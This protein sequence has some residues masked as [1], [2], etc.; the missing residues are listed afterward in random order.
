[1]SDFLIVNTDDKLFRE[2]RIL[3]IRQLRAIA[4][5]YYARFLGYNY[6][7]SINTNMINRNEGIES[8][9][10]A[11]YCIDNKMFE[12]AIEL[13]FNIAFVFPFST[14]ELMS[15][16]TQS[17]MKFVF[18][19]IKYRSKN[20]NKKK[21]K[22]RIHNGKVLQWASAK[23]AESKWLY[24]YGM[25]NE[26]S[27]QERKIINYKNQWDLQLFELAKW[28]ARVDGDFYQN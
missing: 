5:N 3:P 22:K 18:D 11:S 25:M 10:A 1:M 24:T 27:N 9:I 2:S 21:N 23:A 14:H 20:A 6:S 13:M 26:M 4:S 19:L 15:N 28:I 17:M 16:K 7:I 8:I 12:N